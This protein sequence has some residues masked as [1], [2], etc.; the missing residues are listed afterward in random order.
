MTNRKARPPKPTFEEV[1]RIMALATEPVYFCPIEEDEI[2]A[3]KTN[4]RA[5]LRHEHTREEVH[6]FLHT[7]DYNYTPATDLDFQTEVSGTTIKLRLPGDAIMAKIRQGPGAEPNFRNYATVK[8][9]LAAAL[10]ETMT[11]LLADPNWNPL[12]DTSETS[13]GEVIESSEDYTEAGQ[14][15]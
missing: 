14:A 3:P 5:H 6:K 12:S 10:A 11:A 15:T 9:K 1:D 4:L 2:P 7:W 13:R 8:N